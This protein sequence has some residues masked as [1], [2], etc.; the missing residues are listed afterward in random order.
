M[1]ASEEAEAP[2]CSSSA[3]NGANAGCAA[4]SRDSL[5]PLL[6]CS[7]HRNVKSDMTYSS[8]MLTR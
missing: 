8:Q 5:M 2:G 7:Q 1:A 6:Q 3:T 4:I